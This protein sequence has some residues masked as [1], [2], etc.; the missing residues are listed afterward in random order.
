[1]GKDG[2]IQEDTLK[3][4]LQKVVDDIPGLKKQLNGVVGIT[5]G[6]DTNNNTNSNNSVFDFGFAGVRPK[7]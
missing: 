1:M 7:K 6:A 2:K 5:V 3:T 4:A